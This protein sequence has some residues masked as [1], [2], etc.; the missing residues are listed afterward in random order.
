MFI[1]I[2]CN[3]NNVFSKLFEMVDAKRVIYN[4]ITLLEQYHKGAYICK[5]VPLFHINKFINCVHRLLF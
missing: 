4:F 2:N 3:V 5:V 1:H